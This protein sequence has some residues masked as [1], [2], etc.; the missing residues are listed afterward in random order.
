MHTGAGKICMSI[1]IHLLKGAN[2]TL[3]TLISKE[4]DLKQKNMNNN[5]KMFENIV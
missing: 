4:K 1:S 2:F 3:Q 5:R